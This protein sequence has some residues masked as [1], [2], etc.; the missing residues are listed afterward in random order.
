MRMGVVDAAIRGAVV[1]ID[2][3]GDVF[4]ASAQRMH[5]RMSL[6]AYVFH[7]ECER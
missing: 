1:K 3:N 5:W 6:A 2:R 7:E 4:E